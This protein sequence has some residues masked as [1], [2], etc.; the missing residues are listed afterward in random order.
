VIIAQEVDRAKNK[1]KPR[2]N[3]RDF[4]REPHGGRWESEG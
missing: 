3:L 1:H 4:T 2:I